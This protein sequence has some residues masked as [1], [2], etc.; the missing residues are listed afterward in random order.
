MLAPVDEPK[1]KLSEDADDAPSAEVAITPR[2][3]R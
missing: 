1:Q 3:A 2:P